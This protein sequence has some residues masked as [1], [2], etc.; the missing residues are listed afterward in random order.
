MGSQGIRRRQGIAKT[1]WRFRE[2][3]L[4]LQE[5]HFR[6]ADRDRKLGHLTP[7]KTSPCDGEFARNNSP[8]LLPRRAPVYFWSAFCGGGAESPPECSTKNAWERLSSS[9]CLVITIQ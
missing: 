7:L 6:E 2:P 8:C 9:L 3:C 1:A 4:E 5:P